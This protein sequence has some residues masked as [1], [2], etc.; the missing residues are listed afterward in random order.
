MKVLWFSNTAANADEFYGDTLK[1]TGGWLKSLDKELQNMVDLSIAFYGPNN[2]SFKYINTSYYPI[3]I[4]NSF[5][6]KYLRK[7]FN[8]HIKVNY[9]DEFLKIINT[10]EPDIIHIHGTESTF[11]EIIDITTIPIVVSIQ[12]NI[13][14]YLHKYFN[15]I[16]KTYIKI[17][18]DKT[19]ILRSLF[20][21]NDFQSTHKLFKVHCKNEQRYLLNSNNIIGRTNWDKRISSILSP[22]SKYFHCDEILRDSFYVNQWIPPKKSRSKIIHTTTGSSI[23]KGLETVCYAINI[24]NKNGYNFEWRIT[25]VEGTDLIVRLVK[26]KLKK[27]YPSKGLVFLG[28]LTEDQLVRKM[29]EADIYVMPSHIENSPNSLCEAMI[30]GMPCISTF[31][32]GTGSIL[33]DKEDGLLIQDGDPWAMAGAIL[34]M[35]NDYNCAVIY[36]QN[37]R[38][39]ALMRHGKDKIVLDLIRIYK[40]L[41]SSS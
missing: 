7:C 37:A 29:L 15:G 23:Y 18:L 33:Q 21:V 9:I 10:V 8:A 39:K 27:D 14:V 35:L 6:N 16:E 32:G 4:K 19:H 5:F 11:G 3:K 20:F 17:L 24:L 26:R 2:K 12:G 36:G 31:A 22:N 28:S 25:G 40:K 30:L 34:E 13:T 38:K 41:I 1:G